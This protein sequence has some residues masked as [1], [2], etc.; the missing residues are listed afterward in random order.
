M[1]LASGSCSDGGPEPHETR[2]IVLGFDGMD[3]ELASR[4]MDEGRLPSLAA[5]AGRGTA[6]RLGTAL[7]PQSPVAWSDFITGLDAGGHGIFDFIQ[8][9]PGTMVQYLSTS[10]A[11]GPGA[12]LE[13]G[14]WQIPLSGGEV[15]L[16]RRGTPF[17]EVLQAAGVPTTIVRIP[18]DF[19]PTGTATRELS[20]MGTPDLLGGYGT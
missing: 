8:R 10:A 3:W 15:R 19:P 2:V 17:W 5:L 20:G 16:L 9:D 12:R 11:E 13:W 18:A 7:P 6:Q 1:A 14:S 4:L